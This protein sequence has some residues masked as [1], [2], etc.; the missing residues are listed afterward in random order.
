MLP[1]ASNIEPLLST[2]AH[3]PDLCEIVEMFVEEMPERIEALTARY[4]AMDW[5]GLATTAHQIKGSAG[6]YGFHQITPSAATLERAA[7]EH[8]SEDEIRKALDD[9]LQLCRRARYR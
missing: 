7:R 1:Q 4:E 5:D 9:L 8:Q 6:S 3:D 2:L